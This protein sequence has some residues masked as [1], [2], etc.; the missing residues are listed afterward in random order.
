MAK[1]VITLEDT[2]DS[3][4]VSMDMGE[5]PANLFGSPKLTPAVCMSQQ[6]FDIATES[7]KHGTFPR[8]RVQPTNTTIH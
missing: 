8:H 7:A 5:A 1:I 3:F 6:L 2:G 4:S